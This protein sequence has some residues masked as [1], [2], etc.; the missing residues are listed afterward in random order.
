MSMCGGSSL[1]K[2]LTEG[3]PERLALSPEACL[4]AATG[5]LAGSTPA[6]KYCLVPPHTVGVLYGSKHYISLLCVVGL[7]KQCSPTAVVVL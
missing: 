4:V 3:F 1:F 2:L 7:P 5:E 6:C